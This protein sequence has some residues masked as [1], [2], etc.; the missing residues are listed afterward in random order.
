MFIIRILFY[1]AD[2]TMDS[3][4]LMWLHISLGL[5]SLGFFLKLIIQFGLPNHPARLLAYMV[6]LSATVYF[7]GQAMT[8][9]SFITP[10]FW[11]KWRPLPLVA[12]SLCL[13]LQTIML[14]GNFSVIQQRI[15]SRIIVTGKQIG[16]A[17]V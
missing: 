5:F 8:D 6:G 3:S 10:W 2:G 7:V 4:F 11:I 15:I 16:R 14:V 1:L 17:H 13:L 12:G 9:L